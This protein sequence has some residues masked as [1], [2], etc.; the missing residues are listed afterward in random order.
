MLI[1]PITTSSATRKQIVLD[2]GATQGQIIYTVPENKT[3]T[4]TF[5]GFPS[6]N[7]IAFINDKSFHMTT[8]GVAA[9]GILPAVLVAGTVLKAAGSSSGNCSFIGVEE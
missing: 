9:T 2:F 8:N 6:L 7:G 1:G 3:C 5:I 4:G